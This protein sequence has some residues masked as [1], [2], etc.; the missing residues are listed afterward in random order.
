MLRPSGPLGQHL[1]LVEVIL[2][3]RV[4]L[5]PHLAGG[6]GGVKLHVHHRVIPELF[7]PEPI[8]TPGWR[9]AL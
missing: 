4:S 5:S 6:G 7:L 3:V 1:S 2:G 8:C 9:E